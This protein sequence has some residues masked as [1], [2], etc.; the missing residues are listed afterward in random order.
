ME[1]KNELVDGD[2]E[3]ILDHIYGYKKIINYSLI[4]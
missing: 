1:H 4:G 3:G 2:F